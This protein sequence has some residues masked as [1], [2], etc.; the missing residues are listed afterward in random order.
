M[1]ENRKLTRVATKLVTK[2][3]NLRDRVDVAKDMISTAESDSTFIK[4]ITGVET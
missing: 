1:T 2:D 3:L 4:R